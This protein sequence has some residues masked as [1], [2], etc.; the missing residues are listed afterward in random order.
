MEY[1]ITFWTCYILYKEYERVASM[2]LKFLASQRRR[3]EQFTVSPVLILNPNS[4]PLSSYS[5]FNCL[6]NYM[7]SGAFIIH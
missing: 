6:A 2:R 4:L 7:Y 5:D 1:L 3:A